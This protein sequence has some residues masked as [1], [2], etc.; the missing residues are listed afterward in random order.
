[1]EVAVSQTCNGNARI[2]PFIG[3]FARLTTVTCMDYLWMHLF[4]NALVHRELSSSLPSC[5]S[6]DGGISVL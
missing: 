5:A 3:C 1:M 2:F 4:I 6:V